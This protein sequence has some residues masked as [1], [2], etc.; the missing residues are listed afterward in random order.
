MLT[1]PRPHPAD[2]APVLGSPE[3]RQGSGRFWV[4]GSVGVPLGS[5][6][7]PCSQ[8]PRMLTKFRTLT[9]PLVSAGQWCRAFP[10]ILFEVLKRD[11]NTFFAPTQLLTALPRVGPYLK[12]VFLGSFYLL[13]RG[14]AV[15]VSRAHGQSSCMLG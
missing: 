8:P 3:P 6:R 9:A 12:M 5:R 13:R 15:M 2:R 11:D 10:V 14:R 1:V 7:A 4:G